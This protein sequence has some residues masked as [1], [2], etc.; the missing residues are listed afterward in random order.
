[1]SE[2]SLIK[3]PYLPY[4]TFKNV[5][6]N[7]NKNGIIPARIDKTVLAGQSGGTQSYLWSALRFFG[8]IDD[9]KAPTENLKALVNAEGEER[10]KIWREIFDNAYDPII[11]NLDLPTATLGMLHEKFSDQGLNGETVRKCH[12]FYAAGAEDAGITLPPQLKA[13][14]RPSGPRKPRKKSNKPGGGTEP[15]DEF[16]DESENGGDNQETSQKAT[17]LLDRTGKRSFKFKAPPTITSAELE[18]I[19]QWLKFQFIVEE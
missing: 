13:N 3:P 9:G 7:L 6:G 1:M 5:I 12:S 14:T 16:A 15:D 11:G 8:L 4:T 2:E 18:R 17:L 10:K 19:Q